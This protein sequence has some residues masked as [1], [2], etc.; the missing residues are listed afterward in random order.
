[1]FTE[2]DMLLATAL[3]EI[4]AG[5][6]SGCGHDREESMAPEGEFAYDTEILRCHACAAR[7]K[8]LEKYAESGGNTEGV[9][10]TATDRRK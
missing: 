6:C 1:L 3:Q 5:A 2:Q 4:E 10:V 8:A 7:S 9:I